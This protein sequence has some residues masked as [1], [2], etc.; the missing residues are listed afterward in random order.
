ML[1]ALALKASM[2]VIK[3][4][5]SQSFDTYESSWFDD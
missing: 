5:N 2:C 4:K 1:I 3:L